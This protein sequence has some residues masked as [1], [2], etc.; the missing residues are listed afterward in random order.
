MDLHTV[1][2]SA[3]FALIPMLTHARP[4]KFP[5]ALHLKLH[6]FS[7]KACYIYAKKNIIATVIFFLKTAR[8]HTC[9]SNKGAQTT[10]QSNT[11]VTKKKVIKS[12]NL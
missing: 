12:V 4:V 11:K 2:H 5:F 9:S 8:K 6:D 3:I 7:T 1:L 10:P